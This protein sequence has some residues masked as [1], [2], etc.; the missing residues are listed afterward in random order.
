LPYCIF[1]SIVIIANS[2]FGF[3]MSRARL[4]PPD[5]RIDSPWERSPRARARARERGK[6]ISRHIAREDARREE[7]ERRRAVVPYNIT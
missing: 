7:E 3:R 4:I 2:P 5:A 1:R 6:R